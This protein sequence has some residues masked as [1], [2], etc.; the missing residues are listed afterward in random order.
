MR[1]SLYAGVTLFALAALQSA[2]A[3]E[4]ANADVSSSYFDGDLVNMSQTDRSCSPCKQ[5][6]E[7]KRNKAAATLD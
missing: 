1:I 7:L 6:C 3:I 5:A 4:L 2:H